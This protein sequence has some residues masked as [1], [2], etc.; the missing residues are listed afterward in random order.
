MITELIQSQLTDLFRIGLL[1]ALLLTAYRTR[2]MTGLMTPLALG[3]V[4]V[5]ALI[6]LQMQPDTPER[7]MAIGAGVVTNAVLL[8]LLAAARMVILRVMGRDP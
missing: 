4:F 2:A 5:A 7:V 1:T 3:A 6:P 8:G